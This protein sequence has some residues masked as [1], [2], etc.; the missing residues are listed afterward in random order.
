MELT[1]REAISD[2]RLLVRSLVILTL[3][4]AGFVL[5]GPLDTDPS[6]VA[7][8]GAGLLVLTSRLDASEYLDE[9]E[10]ETLVFFM[11]LFILVGALTKVGVIDDLAD[12]AADV[13]DGRLFYASMLLLWISAGLSAIIDNIPYVATMAP[14]VSE[15]VAHSPAGSDP[16]VLWWALALGAD[17][18]GNATAVGA[19][20]NVV[21]VGIAK[22]NGYPIGF[23]EFAKYGAVVAVV[24]LLVCVPYIWLRYFVF[25]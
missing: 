11:G 15:L 20:A 16:T 9:V 12:F 23:W 7:L 24:S 19:G 22:R 4:V 1:E 2:P 8:L 13:I 3:V 21:V 25:A 14:V 17:L 5:S 6:I 18:G 10:W